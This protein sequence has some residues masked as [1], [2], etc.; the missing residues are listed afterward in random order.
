MSVN[1]DTITLGS[2]DLYIVDFEGEMPEVAELEIEA[3]RI[4]SIKGGAELSY[5]PE[6]YEVIDDM[7]KVLKRFVTKEE[8]TF[9]SGILTWNLDVLE[10]LT[11]AGELQ[12]SEEKATLKIGGKGN[13]GIK[14]VV[15]HF[16]HTMEN[17]L[18]VR[19]TLM[20]TSA[21]GF[22]LTFNPEEETVID[23]EFKAMSQNDGTQVTIDMELK[24]AE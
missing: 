2:G 24:K 18:K 11:M 22:V 16:V 7:G 8:V 9:K 15:V 5:A 19:V 10:K 13:R 17:G 12:K 14:Q 21:S 23:A 3:N 6:T 4:G 20:G 1:T